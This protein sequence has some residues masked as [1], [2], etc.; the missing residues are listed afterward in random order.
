MHYCLFP[1]DTLSATFIM[2]CPLGI[3]KDEI[4]GSQWAKLDT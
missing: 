1:I 3:D 4:L 2:H